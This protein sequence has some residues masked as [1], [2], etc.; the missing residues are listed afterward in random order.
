[1][2]FAAAVAAACSLVSFGAMAQDAVASTPAPA[3]P[4]TPAVQDPATTVD[5]ANG[6]ETLFD[7]GANSAPGEFGRRLGKLVCF[8][9]G[10]DKSFTL[11]KGYDAVGGYS[12][13]DLINK[14]TVD[15]SS[16]SLM[17]VEMM[18]DAGSNVCGT[19]EFVY[20]YKND[21]KPAAPPKKK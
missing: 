1:M 16:V 7:A 5:S 10:D 18:Y 20:A 14:Y 9:N 8:F 19:I 17:H 11:P 15:Y 21:L 3:A 2:I 6:S 4:T 12:L 13:V